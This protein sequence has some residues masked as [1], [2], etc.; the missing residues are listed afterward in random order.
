MAGGPGLTARLFFD[1]LSDKDLRKFLAPEILDIL[2]AIFGGHIAGE[3]LKGV[4]TTL[5]D[6]HER[7]AEQ[8]T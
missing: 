3:E 2:D 8:G 6:F 7:F 1:D 5:V 4:A